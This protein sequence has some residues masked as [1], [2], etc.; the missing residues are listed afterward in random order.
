MRRLLLLSAAVL[1]GSSARADEKFVTIKGQ[2]KWNGENAPVAE[3]IDFKASPDEKECCKNAKGGLLSSEFV[4]DPKTLGVKSVIVW[5]RPDDDDREALFPTDKILPALAKPKSMQRV[6]DQPNCQFEP[7][8]LAARAGDTLLVKNSAKIGHN[9]HFIGN[10]TAMTF[11]VIIPAGGE[12][13]HKAPLEADR[14]QCAFKCDIHG[15]MKGGLRV[16]DHPYFATTEND[17]K[18]EIADAP[19]GKWR[20]VYWHEGGFHKGLKGYLGTPVDLKGDKKT[21][22]LEAIKLE[23][24]PKLPS[25]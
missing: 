9:I 22:E 25:K 20:I 8:V 2:V 14:R 13:A 16:F 18:F 24:P 11:N 5:L 1:A 17:G 3:P 19:V 23:P 12:Y 7:R 15:W 6:I 10:S 21:V 4:V